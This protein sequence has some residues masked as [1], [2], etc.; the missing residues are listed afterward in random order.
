ML[1]SVLC[2]YIPVIDQIIPDGLAI[3]ICAV[4]ASVVLALVSPIK[5]AG[6]SEEVK[7]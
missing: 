6:E 3:V 1:L 5:T 2:H 7:E 4:V